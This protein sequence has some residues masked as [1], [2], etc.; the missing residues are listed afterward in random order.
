M[1]PSEPTLAFRM[2]L[3]RQLLVGAQAMIQHDQLSNSPLFKLLD[4]LPCWDFVW[5]FG[6]I[7]LLFDTPYMFCKAEFLLDWARLRGI[8]FLI[9]LLPAVLG[10]AFTLAK[11]AVASKRAAMAMLKAANV[12]DSYLFEHGP[13]V[14]TLLVRAFLVRDTTDLRQMELQVLNFE[15]MIA[16]KERDRLKS[17]Y[18]AAE[19]EATMQEAKYAAQEEF[20]RTKS[21]EEE[22]MTQY[23]AA[24]TKVCDTVQVVADPGAAAA[25]AAEHFQTALAAASGRAGASEEDEVDFDGGTGGASLAGTLDT[26]GHPAS[27]SSR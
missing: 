20:V 2:Q 9:G 12:V 4:V 21:K 15:K 17:E 8:I 19:A 1:G 3:E 11:A 22:F 26:A 13:P 7:A 23:Q 27:S 16:Q 10:L 5:Q 6:G 24:V 14:T 18:E 25:D